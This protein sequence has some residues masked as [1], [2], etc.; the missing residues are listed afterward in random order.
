MQLMYLLLSLSIGLILSGCN[1]ARQPDPLELALQRGLPTR[2]TNSIISKKV[3]IQF[4][5]EVTETSKMLIQGSTLF[6]AG[7]PY[8]FSYWDI[9]SNPLQPRFQFASREHLNTFSPNPDW[10]TSPYASGAMAAM[11]NYILSS[12]AAGASLINNTV[13]GQSYEVKRY[14]PRDISDT[15]VPQDPDYVYRAIVTHPSQPYFYGFREQDFVTSLK[16]DSSG[17]VL[18]KKTSYARNGQKGTCCVTGGATFNGAAYIGFRS[19]VRKYI[20]GSE[21]M[22]Q[23]GG[24]F[25]NINGTNIVATNDLLFV[26]HEAIPGNTTPSG[27]Y[28]VEASG[29][30]I[31]FL[32]IVPIAFAVSPDNRYL[33]ANMDNTAITVYQINW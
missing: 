26:Q 2:A 9:G 28:V 20:F 11:G 17:I 21:G 29:N 23:E 5:Q 13:S 16:L 19:S 18:T 24:V 7:Q 14:P 8:G 22:L 31:A 27:I 4:N 15:Q 1:D 32:P 25:N 6:L 10:Y 30:A 3:A 33:Y 12:G